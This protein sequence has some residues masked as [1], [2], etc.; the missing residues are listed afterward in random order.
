M[1][2]SYQKPLIVL[3]VAWVYPAIGVPM[4]QL[5]MSR[6]AARESEIAIRRAMGAGQLRLIRQMLTGKYPARDFWEVHRIAP[7]TWGVQCY[8]LDAKRYSR[9]SKRGV[10]LHLCCSLFVVSIST[11]VLFGLAPRGTRADSV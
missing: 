3:L 6:N 1:V 5:M 8:L 7:G 4:S 11:G 10:D 2:G 9:D